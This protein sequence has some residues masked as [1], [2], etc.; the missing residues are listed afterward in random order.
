M[1][2][3]MQDFINKCH[4]NSKAS[5]WWADP[6]TGESL[7][8]GDRSRFAGD[9]A[10]HE[11]IPDWIKQTYFPYVV[12]TKIALIH[13]EISEAME[14]YRTGAMD[15]KLPNF[16]GITVELADAMIRIGDLIAMFQNRDDPEGV[17]TNEY[18]LVMAIFTKMQYN[19]SR[20]DHTL[21]K[22]RAVSGK[23]F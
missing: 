16:F 3:D 22:R 2:L 7:I 1:Q 18:H 20:P 8:P 14:A 21:A 10:N 9:F 23:K 15:D 12:A 6:I 5:G 19:T 11:S 13:S 4:D 17:L